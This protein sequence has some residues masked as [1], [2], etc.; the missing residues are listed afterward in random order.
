MYVF[1]RDNPNNIYFTHCD[2]K[3]NTYYYIASWLNGNHIV[4]YIN[5]AGG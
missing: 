4:R 1:L 3:G 5:L 2:M